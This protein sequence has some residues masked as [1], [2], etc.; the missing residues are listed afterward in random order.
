MGPSERQSVLKICSGEKKS[1]LASGSEVE[2]E[3][4]KRAKMPTQ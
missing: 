1:R 2:R 3:K 4:K